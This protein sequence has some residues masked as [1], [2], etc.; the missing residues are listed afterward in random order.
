MR[1]E[2]TMWRS[3]FVILLLASSPALAGQAST[4]IHVGITITGNPAQTPP[5]AK[6]SR[7]GQQAVV[8]AAGGARPAVKRSAPTRPRPPQ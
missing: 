8:G 6:A 3:A 2:C 7:S 5:K 4:V 1:E